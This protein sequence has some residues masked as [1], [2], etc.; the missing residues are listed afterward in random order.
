[1]VELIAGGIILHGNPAGVWSTSHPG[2]WPQISPPP[3]IVLPSIP[4][5]EYVEPPFNPGPYTFD[6]GTP[7][8]L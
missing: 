6:D 1:M 4:Q 5:L 2:S 3:A 8:V 7:I